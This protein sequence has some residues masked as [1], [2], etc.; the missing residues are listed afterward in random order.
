LIVLDPKMNVPKMNGAKRNANIEGVSLRALE[1]FARLA[2]RAAGLQ[3][4]VHILITSNRAL[5]ALNRQFRKKDKAT[6]VLSF[7]PALAGG[8][9]GDIAISAEIA[10]QQ[11]Q[12]LG[13]SLAQELKVLMLHGMLHLAGYDHQTDGGVMARKEERLRQKLGLTAGLIRRAGIAKN[14]THRT[15]RPTAAARTGQS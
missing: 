12:A 9:A 5:R 10:A 11:A 8:Y 3:G 14:S 1:R 6:D 7:P 4:D 2:R 13:H 15:S